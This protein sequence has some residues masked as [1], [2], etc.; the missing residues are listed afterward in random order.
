L[1]KLLQKGSVKH[2]NNWPKLKLREKDGSF[3]RKEKRLAYL[4]SLERKSGKELR[5]ERARAKELKN[6]LVK[7]NQS[8]RRKKYV[9][10]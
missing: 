3:A 9:K 1:P 7:C 5:K 10:K 6:P 2:M 8:L 4:N